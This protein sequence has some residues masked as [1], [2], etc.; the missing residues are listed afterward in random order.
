M[1]D[2]KKTPGR[3]LAEE[4]TVTVDAAAALLGMSRNGTVDPGPFKAVA[5][6][7]WA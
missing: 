2:T 4:P 1:N 3:A 7:A 6:D 5:P